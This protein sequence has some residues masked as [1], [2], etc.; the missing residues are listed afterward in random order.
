MVQRA[1][2]GTGSGGG[3]GGGGIDQA[4]AVVLQES[5]ELIIEL[6]D[7]AGDFVIYTFDVLATTPNS[8]NVRTS[9]THLATGHRGL[10]TV[11]WDA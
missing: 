2:A 8:R 3:A 7:A 1:P 4:A 9:L 5:G 6:T 11:G 10:Y